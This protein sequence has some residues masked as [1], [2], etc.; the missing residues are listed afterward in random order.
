MVD[1]H[2]HVI[3]GVDDGSP[4]IKESIR[5][6]LE[7][8][9]LGIKAIIATPHFCDGIFHEQSIMENY[10]ELVSRVNDCG[11]NLHLGYEVFITPDLPD[12]VILNKN[13]CLDDS[14]FLLVELPFDIIPAYSHDV[15]YKLHLE[16]ITTIIAHPERNRNI[17][18]NF[19]AFMSLIERG[20]LLQLD[21]ASIVGVYG[22]AVR[23]FAKRL[24]KLNLAHIVASDAH[25]AEDY[26]NWYLQAR[27]QVIKWAGVEYA[28][29][30][31][32]QN[33]ELILSSHNK[34][35]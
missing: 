26:A 14:S 23:N 24:I 20:C 22:P 11:V 25:S 27:K 34:S 6:V 33:P 19:N 21:A 1:I 30:L 32:F 2:S 7:A 9:K 3:F 17:V 16:N 12:K 4:T 5:M 15:I 10:H 35:G 31:F 13:L 29:R 28:D 8:E 18:N